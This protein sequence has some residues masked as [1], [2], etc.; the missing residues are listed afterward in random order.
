LLSP[1]QKLNNIIKQMPGAVV[2]VSGGVDSSLLLAVSIEV[3]GAQNVLAITADTPSLARSELH[4]VIDLCKQLKV[5]LEIIKPQEFTNP[6]Y[7]ANQGDRCFWCKSSFFELA[8]PIAQQRAWV[9][10][11]GENA[12]DDPSDR[13]GSRAAI[14]NNVCAPLREAGMDKQAVRRAARKRNLACSD[15]PAMPCLSSRIPIGIPVSLAAL[16][17]VEKFESSLR[18]RGFKIVRARD[19]GSCEVKLEV[20][21]DELHTA[22]SQLGTI[23]SLA[24][25]SGYS[26]LT[27]AIYN[28]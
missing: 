3:L 6:N 24:A 13:P 2:A 26:Q 27:L 15:K 14:E 4:D 8:V 10:C 12:S 7:L 11:Y 23:T 9:M 28:S 21:A 19:Y 16:E 25:A 5:S 18:E 1:E 20:G 22:Q 17:R